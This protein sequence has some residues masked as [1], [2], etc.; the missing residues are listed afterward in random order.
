MKTN[1]KEGTSGAYSITMPPI[2]FLKYNILEKRERCL[3]ALQEYFK[4]RGAGITVP[5][6][7]IDSNIKVLFLEIDSALKSDILKTTGKQK[8]KDKEDLE[9]IFNLVFD[10]DTTTDNQIKAFRLINDW[11]YKKGII[12]FDSFKKIDYSNMAEEDRYM[13]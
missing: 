10:K 12:K 1:K 13:L 3:M 4:G 11:L 8:Q 9:S 6:Y 5:R 7:H 2:D